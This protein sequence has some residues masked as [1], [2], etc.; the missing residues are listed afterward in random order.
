MGCAMKVCTS[1]TITL[2]T[3]K[4]SLNSGE[5][6]L[7]IQILSHMCIISLVKVLI[8]HLHHPE[9]AYPEPQLSSTEL[10]SLNT[11]LS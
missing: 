5:R 11:L 4:V 10:Q 3:F 8:H 1:I 2:L 6:H 9:D 7:E